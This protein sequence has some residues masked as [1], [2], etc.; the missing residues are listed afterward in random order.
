MAYNVCL[1]TSVCCST[2]MT[3]EM[4]WRDEAVTTGVYKR[5]VG[6]EGRI[7]QAK[8]TKFIVALE[9]IFPNFPVSLGWCQKHQRERRFHA[10]MNST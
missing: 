7:V 10:S 8:P 5:G 1:L 9:R 2:T 6:G 4:V 3:T